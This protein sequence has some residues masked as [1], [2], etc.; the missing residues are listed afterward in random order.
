MVDRSVS[1]L[2]DPR[3]RLRELFNIIRKKKGKWGPVSTTFY[4]LYIIR[5]TLLYAWG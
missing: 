1:V 4:L 3:P 2:A 5:I